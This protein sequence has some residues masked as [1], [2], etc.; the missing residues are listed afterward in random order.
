MNAILNRPID[1]KP[2][3]PIEDTDNIILM[4]PERKTIISNF[5]RRIKNERL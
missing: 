2:L 3:T 1:G 4:R 5:K